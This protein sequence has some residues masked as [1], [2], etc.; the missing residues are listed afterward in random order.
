MT[1]TEVIIIV[2]RLIVV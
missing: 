1:T 2:E